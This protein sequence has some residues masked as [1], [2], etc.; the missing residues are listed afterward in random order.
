[1]GGGG[2][3][4]NSG[5][6]TVEQRSDPWAYQQGPLINVYERAQELPQQIP[7][8]YPGVVPF[9]PTTAAAQIAQTNRAM[10]GN[11]LTQ[12]GQSAIGQTASG[13]YLYG[14]PGFNAALESAHRQIAPMV[15]G[16]FE[17]AGRYGSGLQQATEMQVLGD[18]FA[19]M[20]GQE[21]QRQLSA[22]QLAPT[23]AQADYAD[24]GRLSEVGAQ[25]EARAQAALDDAQARWQFAQGTPYSQL[26]TMSQVIQGGYP[27]GQTQTS[28]PNPRTSP[29]AS[30]LGGGLLGYGMMQM[31]FFQPANPATGAAA[32]G[33]AAFAPW[34]PVAGA[35][36]GLLF[37]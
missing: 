33:G 1:M 10:Q 37:G 20:Y 12:I 7:Y 15:R 26:G 13:N 8:P 19:N 5:S 35:G 6:H 21:R 17:G 24:I 28:Q 36:L 18:V 30:A 25:Q 11:P 31:P 29:M 4:G 14:Q 32:G 27:G 16:Q 2:K 9:S 34:L 22:A 3:G 23:M